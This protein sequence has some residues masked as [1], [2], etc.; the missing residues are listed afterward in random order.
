MKKVGL[1]AGAA[2]LLTVSGVYG[3]WVYGTTEADKATH[4]F[5]IALS[6]KTEANRG[7][8]IITHS[9]DFGFSIENSV[10]GSGKHTYVTDFNITGELYV[11]FTPNPSQNVTQIPMAWTITSSYPQYNGVDLF[12]ALPTNVEVI[13]C[14]QFTITAAQLETALVMNDFKLD[15]AAKYDAFKAVLDSGSLLLTVVDTAA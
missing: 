1:L 15:T 10:D 5:Y 4:P 11:T 8:I 14:T 3:A 7:E 2:V 12:S 6:T 9:Q 13:A